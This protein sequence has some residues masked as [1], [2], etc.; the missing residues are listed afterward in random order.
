MVKLEVSLIPYGTGKPKTIGQMT[1]INI[2]TDSDGN[3]ADYEVVWTDTKGGLEHTAIVKGHRRE[4]GIWA[5]VKS[6]LNAA[7][8]PRV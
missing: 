3:L 1:I 6:A 4:D 5:L 8:P 7:P 2:T